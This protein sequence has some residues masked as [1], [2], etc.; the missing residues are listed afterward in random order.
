MSTKYLPAGYSLSELDGLT[1]DEVDDRTVEDWER[2]DMLVETINETHPMVEVAG[3]VFDPADVLKSCDPILWGMLLADEFT[4]V[5]LDD[6]PDEVCSECGESLDD[7]EGFN[8][9]CGNCADA[10]EPHSCENC[11]FTYSTGE[12]GEATC[13]E[14]PVDAGY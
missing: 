14:T 7:G 12:G 2:E 9:L 13:C 5:D 11:G 4:E 6:Y 8:G 1:R 10:A 3:A